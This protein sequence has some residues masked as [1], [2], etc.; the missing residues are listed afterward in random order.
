ME[1]LDYGGKKIKLDDTGF[2]VNLEDWD[3]HVAQ[4][5]AERE[6]FGQLD[7]EQLEIIRFMRSYYDK[8][9]SFPILNYVRKQIDQPKECVSE[10]F[11]KPEKAWKIVSLPKLSG[12]N[13]VSVDGINYRLEE[14]C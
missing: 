6:G 1:E 9:N 11:I 5:L 10:E 7:D 13:F 4:L 2:L 3:E 8:F 14:C 12:I